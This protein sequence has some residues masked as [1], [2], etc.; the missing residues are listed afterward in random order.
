MLWTVAGL[1]SPAAGSGR[2]GEADQYIVRTPDGP[3]P[4]PR[5]CP[6]GL[7]AG[8]IR[9][10]IDSEDCFILFQ[11]SGPVAAESRDLLQISRL[12][13]LGRRELGSPVRTIHSLY[14]VA[15]IG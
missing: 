3:V 4:E 1:A 9:D 12:Q 14:P 10:R 15:R 13:S 11:S 8:W 2:I 5:G 6:G 7:P